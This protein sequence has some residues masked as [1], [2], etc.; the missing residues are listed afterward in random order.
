MWSLKHV[1]S[2]SMGFKFKDLLKPIVTSTSLIIYCIFVNFLTELR[3]ERMIIIK[4]NIQPDQQTE[5]NIRPDQQTEYNIKRRMTEDS[6]IYKWDN[7]VFCYFAINNINYCGFICYLSQI[8]SIILINPLNKDSNSE[9]ICNL[10]SKA[11]KLHSTI[12]INMLFEKDDDLSYESFL[13]KYKKIPIELKRSMLFW[14]IVREIYKEAIQH[15]DYCLALKNA[16]E[17]KYE[18]V[19]LFS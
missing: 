11:L 2:F 6:R 16:T 3:T 13:S 17:N 1:R 18:E 19:V 5:C 4:C 12:A 9:E 14:L 7:Q 15:P 8:W 10:N